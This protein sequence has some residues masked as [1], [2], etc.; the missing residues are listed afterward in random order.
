MAKQLSIFADNKPGRLKKITESLFEAKINIRSTTIQDR[1]EYSLV[2]IVVNDPEKARV[3]LKES[4]FACDMQDV[5]AIKIDDQPGGLFHLA[6]FLSES[7]INLMDAYGFATGTV[8]C[9]EVSDTKSTQKLL[10]SA[11]FKVLSDQELYQ[12]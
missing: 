5:L 1:G 7:N 8:F 6:E 9:I 12:Y 11:G 4:G 10:E 3:V 2:K